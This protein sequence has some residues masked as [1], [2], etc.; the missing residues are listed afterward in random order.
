MFFH[1]KVDVSFEKK[2]VITCPTANSSQSGSTCVSVQMLRFATPLS[3]NGLH[4]QRF[5]FPLLDESK[6]G[7]CPILRGSIR[8][9]S[10][11]F[12]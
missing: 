4:T 10:S 1:I 6:F 9:L 11:E 12:R 2:K 7:G 5:G 8:K 3:G